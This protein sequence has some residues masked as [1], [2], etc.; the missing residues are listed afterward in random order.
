MIFMAEKAKSRQE[1]KPGQWIK[2]SNGRV[3]VMCPHDHGGGLGHAVMIAGRK[4]ESENWSINPLGTVTP[5]VFIVMEGCQWHVFMT[6]L[7]W[8]KE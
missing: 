3:W 2:E 5:S 8:G 6:L 7:G 1:M 4:V